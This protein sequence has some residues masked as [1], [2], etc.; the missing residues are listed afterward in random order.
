[1]VV[2]QFAIFLEQFLAP[3][4][5]RNY[6]QLRASLECYLL[7]RHNIGVVFEMRDD[8]FIARAHVG[9]SPPLRNQIDTFGRAASSC[10]AR[11][12]LEL[13]CL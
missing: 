12:M 13:S 8:D 6:T 1:M 2:Q 11:W 9:T 3:V 7:P 4:I 10:A 5:D